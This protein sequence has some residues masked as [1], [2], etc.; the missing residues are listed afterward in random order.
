VW[1]GGEILGCGLF[2]DW[3]GVVGEASGEEH[4]G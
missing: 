1:P 3:G 2:G 4:G